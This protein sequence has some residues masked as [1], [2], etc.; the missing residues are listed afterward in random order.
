[1]KTIIL[2]YS[3]SGNN[4][5]LAEEL[6]RRTGADTQRVFE[7]KRRGFLIMLLDFIF[8]LRRKVKPSY[9]PL[10]DYDRV[11]MI[12]P[13][14]W[15]RIASPM[16]EFIKMERANIRNFS[17]ITFCGA[18]GN[19]RIEQELTRL[20]GTKPLVVTELGA[21][22]LISAHKEHRLGSSYRL[23][24]LDL[25]FFNSRLEQFVRMATEMHGVY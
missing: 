15:G 10:K 16:R 1:M 7:V 17:F 2:Y 18:A 4:E 21:R 14:W 12:A 22:D 20:L 25:Q 6:K 24:K 8:G 11:I 19:Q 13:I 5:L 3:Y 23:K 9:L